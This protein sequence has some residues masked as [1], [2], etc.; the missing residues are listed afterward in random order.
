MK[1]TIGLLVCLLVSASIV[2][3][4][5]ETAPKENAPQPVQEKLPVVAIVLGDSFLIDDFESGSLKSPRDW[6]T[7]D[8][9][10]AK[11]DAN[12]N[13]ALRGGEIAKEVGKYSMLLKGVAKNWY[14]GGCGTY[15]AK[16]G[17]NL[18][19][20]DTF[21]V[22]IYGNGPGSGTMKAE[23]YDD[24]NENWQVEQNKAKNYVPMYDDKFIYEI[25]VDWKGWK[26]ISV[27]LADFVDD[28]PGVGD[29]IWNP[30]QKGNSGGL[31]QLQIICL[32]TKDTGG[33]NFNADNFKLTVKE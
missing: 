31:L 22:D 15:L 5:G 4:M 21:R 1:K 26:R 16:E 25:V 14:A 32:A 3:A 29:D 27:P 10:E 20:F 13:L 28:N 2:L 23:F 9:Q 19:K 11:I 18:G 8:I 24:D 33:I 7:F 12:D 6:W 30:Q 17:Q